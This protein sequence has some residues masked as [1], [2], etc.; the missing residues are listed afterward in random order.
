MTDFSR[1][2]ARLKDGPM[3]LL[4]G[5][6]YLSIETGRDP[7]LAEIRRKYSVESGT[8]GYFDLFAR[9]TGD[10]DTQI[11]AWIDERCRRIAI[12]RWLLEVA[13]LPW[14]GTLASAFDTVWASAFRLPWRDVQP[15]FDDRYRPLDPRS[16][17]LLSCYCLFGQA[18]RPEGPERPPLGK[19]ELTARNQTAI[20]VLRRLPELVTPFGTLVIEGY[21][22]A[23]DWLTPETLM[24]VLMSLGAHQVHL[25]S[26]TSATLDDDYIKEL[27]R[28]KVLVAHHHS[29]GSVISEGV[30]LGAISFGLPDELGTGTSRIGLVSTVLELP[31]DIRHQV[32]QSAIIVDDMA[33]VQPPPLSEDATYR[34]FREFLATS[35]GVPRWS[36]YSRG[37]A[38]ARDYFQELH[39]ALLERLGQVDRLVEAPLLLHGQTGTGKTVALAMLAHTVRVARTHPVL[40]IERRSRRPAF[41]DIGAFCH[42]CEEHG[43]LATVVIWDG[44]LDFNEYAELQRYLASRGRKAVLVG[45]S[46]FLADPPRQARAILAPP[47][48]LPSEE[49]RFIEFLRSIDQSFAI[50]AERVRLLHDGSFLV[51]LYRLL[52]PTRAGVRAGLGRELEQAEVAVAARIASQ[53][54]KVNARTALAEALVHA[55]VVTPSTLSSEPVRQVAGESLNDFQDLTA[56][57]MVAARHGIRTPIEILLRAIGHEHFFGLIELLKGVDIVRWFEDENGNIDSRGS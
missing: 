36:G 14:N 37:F 2:Y 30:A 17:R 55:N 41:A 49:A 43:A 50:L 3:F 28:R 8:R 9:Q 15:I 19:F 21:D 12:P 46:Y 32:Q 47:E 56:L 6:N 20:A 10:S 5:Q 39:T 26:A 51:A 25:F 57:V 54:T 22:G 38:F 4:L 44:M 29:L 52:P 42:W 1:L 23:N 24:P 31:R 13:Q 16:R 27:V 53:P 34:E 45:S 40:F 7:L 33:T 48:I 35:E 11:L 18:N